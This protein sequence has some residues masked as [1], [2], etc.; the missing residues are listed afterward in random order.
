VARII[1]NAIM[2]LDGYTVDADGS[3][4]WAA[5]DDE[6]HAF[7]NDLIRPVAT[8]LYGRR[9]YETMVYWETALD[10]P[11]QPAVA[12][13]FARIWQSADKI[14][15]S[16][17]LDR[18]TSKKTR[19]ERRFDAEAL[20]RMKQEADRDLAVGGT[21]LAAH[22]IKA[23]LVDEYQLFVAPHIVGGGRRA[24]PDGAR[25]NLRLVHT[26]RFAGGF[27]YMSHEVER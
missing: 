24:L 8:Y 21:E 1:Y 9:M 12:Q 20:R 5:P 7:V 23:G 25:L 15:Y 18:A 16:T 3:F 22:A 2:S 13:D 17:T 6:V 27:L 11:D 26:R 14:V 4:D 10:E 19:I